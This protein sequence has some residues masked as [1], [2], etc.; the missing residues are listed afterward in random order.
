M[1]DVQRCRQCYISF[2]LCERRSGV[3][4]ELPQTGG[5]GKTK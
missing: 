5:K 3:T 2:F 1:V 4:G